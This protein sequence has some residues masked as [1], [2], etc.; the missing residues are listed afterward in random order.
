MK[1]LFCLLPVLMLCAVSCATFPERVEAFVSEVESNYQVFTE[2]EW[3]DV[4]SRYSDLKF[5]YADKYDSLNKEEIELI[6]KAFVRY[7]IAYAKGKVKKG[8]DGVKDALQ[9]L[10]GLVEMW[11]INSPII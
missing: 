5:E 11:K 7:D 1:K 8:V 2:E 6:Q 10:G 3:A 9:D 4:E